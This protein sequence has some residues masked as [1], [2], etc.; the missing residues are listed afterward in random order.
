MTARRSG[1]AASTML[2][3]SDFNVIDTATTSTEALD[4]CRKLIPDV[5]LVDVDLGIERG[6]D[7]ATALH[8]GLS[9]VSA[10]STRNYTSRDTATSLSRLPSWL[11]AASA[12]TSSRR[13]FK[14][15]PRPWP[16]ST[17]EHDHQ[18]ASAAR[19]LV[20]RCAPNILRALDFTGF[21][22]GRLLSRSKRSGG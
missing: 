4:C 1:A 21:S 19:R 20:T 5:A 12:S 14:R 2:D 7:V 13:P 11:P 17:S 22:T 18:A 15:G 3:R 16:M 10:R 6:F 8:R 9:P